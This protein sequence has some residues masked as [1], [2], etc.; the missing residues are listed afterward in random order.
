MPNRKITISDYDS[1]W[2][3]KFEQEKIHLA[4]LLGAC[5]VDCFHIGSTAVPGLA[6]KP[7][8]DML[9]IVSSLTELD[10]LQP[11]LERSGYTVKGENGI[12]GRRY[13]FKGNVVRYF[14]IHAYE[15]NHLDIERHLAFRDYLRSHL[16]IAKQYESIKK[17]ALADSRRS[18]ER[19]IMYKDA[20][21]KEHEAIAL[22]LIEKKA[23]ND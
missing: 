12:S 4:N 17:K 15:I 19:Y 23:K 14:H 11:V 9:I 22:S 20:F 1:H 6:A 13:F 7:I 18:P 8:I 10:L 21:I 5:F 3:E 16:A 2:P